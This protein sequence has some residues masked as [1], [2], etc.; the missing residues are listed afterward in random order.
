MSQK[1]FA[2][3]L[4]VKPPSMRLL[5]V[6]QL[7][8]YKV[9]IIMLLT[10]SL[11]FFLYTSNILNKLLHSYFYDNMVQLSAQYQAS[12]IAN[13]PFLLPGSSCKIPN[14]N[15]FEPSLLDLMSPPVTVQCS[16]KSPL[17]HVQPLDDSRAQFQLI[18]DKSTP[19]V[20]QYTSDRNSL[21]C[22]YSVITR[23]TT[24]PG[25]QHDY[26]A[27]N[28]YKIQDCIYFQDQTILDMDTEFLF[29]HCYVLKLFV[30]RME[31]YKMLHTIIPVKTSVKG[32]LEQTE[33]NEGEYSN[34]T[35]S[36]SQPGLREP[37][38]GGFRDNLQKLAKK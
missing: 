10:G 2:Q 19:V 14:M 32:K 26:K 25:E 12:V 34:K 28:R 37:M 17:T 6:P 15:P 33:D 23:I 11:W 18:V 31:V 36:D 7:R 24:P 38:S 16:N 5:S 13:N 35:S 8:R 21:R 20:Q 3:V 22:C 9:I 30:F 1:G 27:D 4:V 29:V